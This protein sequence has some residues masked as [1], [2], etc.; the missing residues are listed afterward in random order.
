MQ[1]SSM[2]KALFF[3]TILT[4]LAWPACKQAP[5]ALSSQVYPDHPAVQVHNWDRALLSRPLPEKI[6]P[7]NDLAASYVLRWNEL[8]D[9]DEK[10]EPAELSPA[11]RTALLRELASLPPELQRFMR[12]HLFSIFTCKNLGGSAMAG[13]ILDGSAP[14]G[15][16]VILD[17]DV[18]SRP[19]NEWITFKENTVFRPQPGLSYRVEMESPA[20]NTVAASMRFIF[21]HELGHILGQ[22]K[23]TTVPFTAR[24]PVLADRPFLRESFEQTPDGRIIAIG[25]PWA[26]NVKFYRK[27]PPF[28][29]SESVSLYDKL[30]TTKFPSLYAVT[31]AE[32]DWAETV[33]L[34][35][36][37]VLL[38]K[39]YRV[40]LE[41]NGTSRV[42]ASDLILGEAL[43][44]KRRIVEAALSR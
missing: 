18:L 28:P 39:H 29:L 34:Y 25:A 37:C 1:A 43:K 7:L 33:A 21:V 22:V 42:L 11:A 5:P 13:V 3:S 16:F 23:R 12:D 30:K 20:S 9:F 40:I 15:G 14:M 41:E 17:V 24:N 44:E 6:E 26:E 36:H 27:E 2:R 32:E 38:K 4:F 31:D 19:A 10:P 35:V 8:E